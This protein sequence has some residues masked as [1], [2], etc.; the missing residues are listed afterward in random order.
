[1]MRSK[2][3][4]K[5]VFRSAFSIIFFLILFPGTLPFAT[6]QYPSTRKVLADFRKLLERPTSG[7]RPFFETTTTDSVIIDKGYF[8]SEENE[9]VPV[10][11]YKPVSKSRKSFPVVICL[12][13]TGGKKDEESMKSILYR[14]SKAGMIAVAIDAR[15]HG[16]RISGGAHGSQE[17]IEAIKEAWQN[18]DSSRQKYPL[19]FDTVFDLWR[20]TDYLITRRDVQANRIGM[21]GI[22][23]GG[24]ETWLA[25]STDR[26]IKVAVPVISAQSF[27]WSIENN[28]W[29]GRAGTIW[30]VHEQVAKDLGDS[31]VNKNNVRIF[32]NKMLPGITGEFDCPSMLRLFAPRPLMVLNNEKDPNCPL[33]GAKLAFASAKKVYDSLKVSA[34]LITDITPNEPHRF[35]ERHLV[36]AI[37]WMKKWL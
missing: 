15:F 3:L 18:K 20:L 19:Y 24:I 7:L 22:S 17:Y 23:M 37:D 10:L 26:R 30:P 16:E 4:N 27:K 11:I 28:Q 5:P 35:T 32:W 9:R 36:L 8:Y 2:H 31:T 6:A 33:P 14:F 29:Q 21:M 1:M 13:G 12:H 25:A 34:R